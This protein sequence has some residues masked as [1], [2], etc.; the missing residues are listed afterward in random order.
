M[1]AKQKLKKK[2]EKIYLH[3]RQP[4]V[5]FA[6]NAF[7]KEERRITDT[8]RSGQAIV[9]SLYVFLYRTIAFVENTYRTSKPKS[10]LV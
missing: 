7:V 3:Y 6:A 2:K 9:S 8:L 4:L 10:T 5:P 1:C